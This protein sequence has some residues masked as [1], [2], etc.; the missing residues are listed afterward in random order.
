MRRI[1][2]LIPCLI[3]V[4]FGQGPK[5]EA[6]ETKV[7]RNELESKFRYQGGTVE[8]PGGIA[9]LQIPKEFRYLSPEDTET[10]LTEGWGNPDGS[11]TLGMI[12]PASSSPLS[13]NGWG[14]IIT[15]D[16]DGFVK[17]DE[18]EKI[19]YSELLDQ[20]KKDVEEANEERKEAG[21]GAIHVV[22]WAAPPHYDKAAHKLYWA[23]ELKFEG[24][25]E[26]TLNYNIRVLGRRGV[27]VLNA[28][29]GRSQLALVEKDMP[30]VMNLVEFQQGHRYSDFLPSSDKVAT[31]GIGALI[32]G[33]VAAKV[34][35]F[36][37]LIGLIIAFKK[38]VAVAVV[39]IGSFVA[40]L[41][42]GKKQADTGP[43]P[44]I[45][46]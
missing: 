37:L 10:L 1:F 8:L 39:A 11:G 45:T 25:P 35:L 21:Y 46:T 27:L 36:K 14:V 33:K 22:G 34:G 5:A 15:F 18:A 7:K 2:W 29:A 12:V 9:K 30:A 32:A 41:F 19:N 6:D 38:L 31:Y 43:A 40:K 17:D 4:L 13:E 16:E 44:E 24:S 20:M 3:S 28:V 42:K 26:N 23:K